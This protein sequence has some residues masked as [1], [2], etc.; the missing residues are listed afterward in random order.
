MA[1]LEAGAAGET[2]VVERRDRNRLRLGARSGIV[3]GLALLAALVAGCSKTPTDT[4]Y[5]MVAAAK[6]GDRE[7]FL[8]TF[9][10]ESR[11]LIE[12]LLELSDV[13]GLKRNDPYELLVHTDV[14]GEE[15]G[16]PEPVPGMQ[17]PR[18]VAYVVVQM[19][20]RRR[21]I[22][23]IKVDG[24]WKIDAFDLEKFWEKRANF[25]Y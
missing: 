14:A 24:E 15:P 13:Y 11:S 20:N 25:S 7:T 22:K 23:M 8:N 12:A 10:A 6:M 1:K 16:E 9:T 4:Y 17:E 3:A 18:E 19:K 21:K 5:E 2:G